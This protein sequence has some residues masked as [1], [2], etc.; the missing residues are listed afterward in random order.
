MSDT[1]DE[2]K[3]LEKN[4]DTLGSKVHRYKKIRFIIKFVGI[5]AM[6]FYIIEKQWV[7]AFLFWLLF[8]PESETIIRWIK[9]KNRIRHK[10]FF[11][12]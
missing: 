3:E 11:G 9:N 1:K 5:A 8:F 4:I 10:H 7:H 2:I 6:I 12:S